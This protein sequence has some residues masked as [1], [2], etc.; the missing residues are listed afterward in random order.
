MERTAGPQVCV[1]SAWTGVLLLSLVIVVQRSPE[2][3]NTNRRHG[4]HCAV[5]FVLRCNVSVVDAL[6]KARLVP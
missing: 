4:D 2:Q 1:R 5:V 3:G 6:V